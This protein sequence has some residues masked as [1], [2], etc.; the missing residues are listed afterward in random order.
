MRKGNGVCG[1]SFASLGLLQPKEP[2]PILALTLFLLACEAGQSGAR[3]TV[4]VRGIIRISY[5]ARKGG[6]K[7]RGTEGKISRSGTERGEQREMGGR[8]EIGRLRK[9][10]LKIKVL[11]WPPLI[12]HHTPKLKMW[13]VI[14]YLSNCLTWNGGCH[15]GFTKGHASQEARRKGVDERLLISP[16]PL[17]N[18]FV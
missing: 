5:R 1:A 14:T 3:P 7:R 6:G 11:T 15:I 17:R 16:N 9:A 4:Y 8:G 18:Y 2:L 10:G 13:T 12:F